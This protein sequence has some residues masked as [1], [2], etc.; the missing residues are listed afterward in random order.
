M[1]SDKVRKLSALII[2]GL[3]PVAVGG[4]PATEPNCAGNVPNYQLMHDCLEYQKLGLTKRETLDA[5]FCMAK[6]KGEGFDGNRPFQAVAVSGLLLIGDA[7]EARA[8]LLNVISS[9]DVS[10]EVHHA[11]AAYLV[12]V[13][14]DDSNARMFEMLKAAVAKGS[15]N[16]GGYFTYFREVGYQPFTDWLRGEAQANVGIPLPIPFLED[17]LRL[18][19]LRGH[20]LEIIGQLKECDRR[21]DGAWLVRNAFKAGA[22]RDEVRS[23]VLKATAH[24]EQSKGFDMC[25]M[26]SII[27]YDEFVG[28]DDG[29]KSEIGPL[30]RLVETPYEGFLPKWVRDSIKVKQRLYYQVDSE[31]H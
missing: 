4:E 2:F 6:A 14:D 22:T 17:Y 21:S 3:V 31:D 9:S 12:Y 29:M 11:A 13:S 8:A 24:L 16:W 19:E 26:N 1:R 15:R 27:T 7:K 28:L 20:R 25:V 23:A 5:L 18:A 30:W 10:M